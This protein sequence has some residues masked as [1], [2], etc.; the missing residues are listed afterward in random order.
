MSA[1]QLLTGTR[2]ITALRNAT[3]SGG[4][5]TLATGANLE[6]YGL[7]S[8]AQTLLSIPERAVP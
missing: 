3:G 6:T 4:T 5:L 2:T 7:L 8:G 1:N